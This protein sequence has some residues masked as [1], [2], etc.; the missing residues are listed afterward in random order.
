MKEFKFFIKENI[1]TILISIFAI[2]GVII[3]GSYNV[4]DLTETKK[5][6]KTLENLK[7]LRIALE[8]Y[9][10]LTK[11][12]PNLTIPEVKD[13]LKL[14]DFKNSKGE[15]ISFAE[16]YG[17]NSLPKTLKGLDIL[18]S[19]SVYDISDFTKG[20]NT[21]GWNYN[22]SGNT[23]EIHV[24]LPENIYFQGIEWNSY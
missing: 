23:G 12:Y 17:R 2:F 20:N 18:E 8:K 21:G 10:Q 1:I 5:A 3:L 4:K 7:E 15:V 11:T 19:N 22:Y 13:N 9:Y 14:L 6:E 24:N 16:I